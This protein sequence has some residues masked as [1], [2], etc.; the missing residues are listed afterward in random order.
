MP[1]ISVQL[2]EAEN[3]RRPAAHHHWRTRSGGVRASCSRRT[4]LCAT[5]DAITAQR[6]ERDDIGVWIRRL[7]SE[8][9]EHRLIGKRAAACA[10]ERRSKKWI[11]FS[12][13]FR[14]RGTVRLPP[15]LARST[16]LA[17]DAHNK[18]ERTS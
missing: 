15:L 12:S 14:S 10:A 16:G 8:C 6:R 1:S 13:Q 5:H 9:A 11:T 4:W 18:H 7:D 2:S 3:R 17:P